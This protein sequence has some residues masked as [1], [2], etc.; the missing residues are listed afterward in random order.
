MNT[1]NKVFDDFM[2]TPDNYN[3]VE[4][5]QASNNKFSTLLKTSKVEGNSMTSE[6]FNRQFDGLELNDPEES[7]QNTRPSPTPESVEQTRT[8]EK[9]KRAIKDDINS[10]FNDFS[11]LD[12]ADYTPP[13]WIIEGYMTANSLNMLYGLRK[14]GKSYVALDWAFSVATPKIDRWFG[15]D[16][17]HGHVIYFA[18]E[19]AEGIKKRLKAWLDVYGIERSEMNLTITNKFPKLDA[20]G[21]TEKLVEYIKRKSEKPALIIFDTLNRC[22]RGDENSTKDA[23]AITDAFTTIQNETGAAVLVLHHAGHSSNSG[24]SSHAR[25]SSVFGGNFDCM[26]KIEKKDGRIIL[27]HEYS[28]D[29][30]TQKNMIFDFVERDTGWRRKNGSHVTA[31]TIELNET[32]TQTK[33]TPKAE[34]EKP[35]FKK[36]ELNAMENYKKGAE[37]FG[38]II[39]YNAQEVIAVSDKNWRLSSIANSCVDPRNR[40][41]E[42]SDVKKKLFKELKVLQKS[43]MKYEEYYLLP[44]TTDGDMAEYAASIK[45]AIQERQKSE[46]PERTQN[47]FNPSEIANN[48]SL[49]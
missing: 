25:G 45:E 19:G 21:M 13:E 31:C 22:M 36:S 23:T 40:N 14:S 30:A 15:R 12:C 9:R 20:L 41:K 47:I 43:T 48:I 6:E 17:T 1:G 29:E 3:P 39:Q 28:K 18:G 4:P 33:A 37:E 2:N 32:L 46:N 49:N 7:Y 38:E 42:F 26:M 34:P 16:I 27:I 11:P 44:V 8:A 24:S 10:L 5:N 35:K